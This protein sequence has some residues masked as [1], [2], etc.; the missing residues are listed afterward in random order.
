MESNNRSKPR[1]VVVGAMAL[2]IPTLLIAMA[3]PAYAAVNSPTIVLT[4]PSTAAISEKPLV[5]AR[6]SSNG[7][8]V[9]GQAVTLTV[10]ATSVATFGAASKSVTVPTNGSGLAN[11]NLTI[12]KA[13]TVT[14]TATSGGSTSTSS[15][16]VE[17]STGTIAFPQSQ[18]VVAPNSDNTISAKV[19]RLT[20]TQLPTRLTLTYSGDVTGPQTALVNIG[21]GVVVQGVR[22]GSTGGTITAAADGFGQAH[23]ALTTR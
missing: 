21:Q 10:D 17:P 18:Q 6:V 5:S 7:A 12:K 11:A 15:I 8:T 14:V 23:L 13:G 9:P 20:G 1:R 16:V 22:V 4:T 2:A 3:T 19:T